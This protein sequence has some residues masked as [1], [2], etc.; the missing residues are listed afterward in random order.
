MPRSLPLS[1]L[2]VSLALAGCSSTTS[3]PPPVVVTPTNANTIKHI[4][5]IMQENRSMDNLF[6]TASLA[7]IRYRPA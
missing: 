6:S 4:V 7:Q 3:T 2:I 1:L 5:I